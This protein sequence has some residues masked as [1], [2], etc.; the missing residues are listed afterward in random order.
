MK[1][2][3]VLVESYGTEDKILLF[4]L[5]GMETKELNIENKYSII[6]CIRTFSTQADGGGE[7]FHFSFELIHFSR[8]P[9]LLWDCLCESLRASRERMKYYE[10]IT[11]CCRFLLSGSVSTLPDGGGGGQRMMWVLMKVTVVKHRGGIQ[12]FTKCSVLFW[13]P[14][15]VTCMC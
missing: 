8:A 14:K 1:T 15:T 13:P 9:D 3:C 12:P 4:F 10:V 7:C 5:N 6:D 11:S 2:N